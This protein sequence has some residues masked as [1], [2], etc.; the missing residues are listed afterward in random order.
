MDPR[1]PKIKTEPVAELDFS[2]IKERIRVLMKNTRA[3]SDAHLNCGYLTEYALEMLKAI[4]T[5]EE[6]KE[7]MVVIDDSD[8]VTTSSVSRETITIKT[9]SG[10]RRAKTSYV[11]SSA[12]RPAAT[13]LHAHLPFPSHYLVDTETGL[14]APVINLEGN[15]I[16]RHRVEDPSLLHQLLT[17]QAKREGRMIYGDVA[18]A[19]PIN[20]SRPHG[21]GHVLAFCASPEQ[22]FYIDAQLYN[23][24][25][26]KGEPVFD[27]LKTALNSTGERAF[28]FYNED[29]LP[30]GHI[31]YL[32][33]PMCFYLVY[34]YGPTLLRQNEV[35]ENDKILNSFET[36]FKN[37][38]ARHFYEALNILDDILKQ[39]PQ[40]VLSLVIRG[41]IMRRMGCND[42]ALINLNHAI[43]LDHYN[44]LAFAVR[45][46][47]YLNQNSLDL[48]KSDIDQAIFLNPNEEMAMLA[49][50]RAYVNQNDY[51]NALV[52]L[53]KTL[54][55]NPKNFDALMM[56]A[57][58]FHAQTRYLNERK[59]LEK[60]MEEQP[61]LS[62]LYL[63]RGNSF[64]KTC[65][66]SKAFADYQKALELNP[67]NYL[68]YLNVGKIYASQKKYVETEYFFKKT[69]SLN[70]GFSKGYAYL[71][72]IYR[73]QNKDAQA[74]EC[75]NK[76]LALNSNDYIALRA[77]AQIF[78]K[79]PDTLD[80]ALRDIQQASQ[81]NRDWKTLLIHQ[82][83][84]KKKT[85]GPQQASA[86]SSSSQI[87]GRVFTPT[88][89]PK[90]ADQAR[91]N[92]GI[93][94]SRSDIPKK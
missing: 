84:L 79:M 13:G 94:R 57:E 93:K 3:G 80:Q 29:N 2:E 34:G 18:F 60:A 44:S 63:R 28:Y 5:N 7:R 46:F 53:E 23:G 25:T 62:D 78:Q 61:Q 27:D 26:K 81:I 55:I 85:A 83:I 1:V 35:E 31:E 12:P 82:E 89:H 41:D 21:V 70:P 22:V 14:E 71:G 66:Y 11:T 72:D 65:E 30:K 40:H 74:L 43:E 86:A 67:G 49:L 68:A 19:P 32:F 64:H 42:E 15:T 16:Y 50:S 4:L 9:E 39:N 48:A 54:A 45:G 59:I 51:K 69:I 75:L 56:Q 87:P 38:E 33:Q 52:Q 20:R 8:T 47:V 77:R 36:A 90:G 37:Y 88:P 76:A 73:E 91:T 6:I 10:K 92:R 24:I 17:E 58:I